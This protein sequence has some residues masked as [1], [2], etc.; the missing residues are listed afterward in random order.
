MCKTK[1]FFSERVDVSTIQYEFCED[2]DY[3]YE[4]GILESFKNFCKFCKKVKKR[5]FLSKILSFLFS[6]SQPHIILAIN[7]RYRICLLMKII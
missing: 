2:F 1:D 7:L 5:F 6:T 4:C 3:C